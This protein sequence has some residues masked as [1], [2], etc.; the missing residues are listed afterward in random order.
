M[1]LPEAADTCLAFQITDVAVSV[2]YQIINGL[3]GSHLVID[4]YGITGQ[5]G[6]I[7]VQRHK[8]NLDG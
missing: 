2:P 3:V 5:T 7:I 6:E 8:G 4:G 1:P